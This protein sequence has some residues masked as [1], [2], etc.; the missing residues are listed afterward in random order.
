MISPCIG[1][2]AVRAEPASNPLS[3]SAPLPSSSPL[4]VLSLSL[5]L[6]N[7]L[8][9]AQLSVA[10]V[11]QARDKRV[12]ALADPSQAL[13]QRCQELGRGRLALGHGQKS[14]EMVHPVSLLYRWE[15]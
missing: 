13:Y 6:S 3:L 7:N 9:K 5:S 15:K 1:L 12:L 4:L 14:L 8:K 10:S 2:S 11:S